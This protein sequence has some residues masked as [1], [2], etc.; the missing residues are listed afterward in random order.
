MDFLGRLSTCEPLAYFALV[1]GLELT[2]GEIDF[3]H[4]AGH[5]IGMEDEH[6]VGHAGLG[7]WL[8]M[9]GTGAKAVRSLDIIEVAGPGQDDGGNN[10]PLR[11]SFQEFKDGKAVALLHVEVTEDEGGIGILIAVG[12]IALAHHVGNGLLAALEEMDAVPD[13]HALKGF[14]DKGLVGRF[15]LDNE[16]GWCL[17]FHP[18]CGAFSD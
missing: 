13:A 9:I 4:F 5:P 15:I 2:A 7:G 11:V 14:F 18:W 17:W 1:I 10:G 12:I 16:N 6:E 8:N 3:G